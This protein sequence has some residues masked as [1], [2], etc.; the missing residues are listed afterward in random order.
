LVSLSRLLLADRAPD[1]VVAW[2]WS[3][4][5]GRDR[6]I[7]WSDFRDHVAR[8]AGRLE[9]APAGAWLVEVTDPYAFA[10]SLFALWN[11]GRSAVLPPNLQAGSLAHLENRTAGVL[12]D[13]PERR[14]LAPAIDPLDAG[15]EPGALREL[16]REALALDLF[17]SGSTGDEKRI[18]KRVRH[19]ADEVDQLEEIWGPLVG[20]AIVIS[21]ASQHHLYG[22]LFGILWPLAAGRPICAQQLLRPSELVERA[23][24]VRECV[25]VSVP[26]HL[27]RLVQH[28][29]IGGL[30]GR[31]RAIFSSGGPLAQTTAHAIA[32]ATSLTPIEALGST[33]TGGIAWRTQQAPSAQSPW[34]P[35]PKVE[36]SRDPETGAARVRSPFVSVGDPDFGFATADQIEPLTDGRFVLHGRSDRIVKVGEKRL[37]LSAMESDLRTHDL[38]ADAALLLVDRAGESR[39]AAVLVLTPAGERLLRAEGRRAVTL[40]LAGH[41]G[42]SWDPVLVPRLWRT[43]PALP[44]SERGKPSIA[45]L[46]A[47]FEAST[48]RPQPSPAAEDRPE[49]LDAARDAAS[50]QWRCRVPRD[51]SC[52]PGHFPDAPVVPGVLQIDW[53]MDLASELLGGLPRIC[54][55]DPVTFRE[56]LRPG[57]V[58]RLR[59][60]LEAGDWLRF[61]IWSDRAEHASGRARVARPDRAVP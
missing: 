54:E 19:L 58:F 12:S 33:E 1:S 32:A 41:L 3:S 4:A 2:R 40:Q 36:I 48:H 28:R 57:D 44:E 37:D 23:R 34:H 10:V 24:A 22:L 50:A 56:P 20:R 14:A 27:R 7:G 5:S 11:C 29:N 38:V 59:V 43:V 35:F 52:W 55:M 47:L 46:R 42:R 53:A 26:A 51:L 6:A 18:S 49:I 25:L 39:V 9:R 13:R 16:D 45:S 61:R 15:Q 30:E 17:S 21:T 8:L 31:C 60:A